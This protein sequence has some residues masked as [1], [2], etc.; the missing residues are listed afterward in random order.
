[1]ESSVIQLE[2]QSVTQKSRKSGTI[3]FDSYRSPYY[4]TSGSSIMY[5]GSE[6]ENAWN[7]HF[8]YS[9][10]NMRKLETLKSGLLLSN[11]MKELVK[12]IIKGKL[13]KVTEVYHSKS[14][15]SRNVSSINSFN[16]RD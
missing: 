14:I 13:D 11:S 7:K 12:C 2:D 8:I 10:K 6:Q 1:M 15:D 4:G 5:S 3:D 9:F 16:S